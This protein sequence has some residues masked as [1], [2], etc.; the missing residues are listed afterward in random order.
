MNKKTSLGVLLV[1]VFSLLF[2][3]WYQ[4]YFGEKNKSSK[5]SISIPQ[6]AILVDDLDGEWYQNNPRNPYNFGFLK[7][8]NIS[9][10]KRDD[11]LFIRFQLEG[12]LPQSTQ[13][14]PSVDGDKLKGVIF[15]LSI[16]ENYYSADGGRNSGGSDAELK[17]SFY[18]SDQAYNDLKKLTI[19]GELVAGG[20]DHDYF[21][22]RFPYSQ[23][24]FSPHDQIVFSSYGLIVSNNK[25]LIATT[26][27]FKNK[28]R[29]PK[30]DL[31]KIII[32][33]P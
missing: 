3:I 16:D 26:Y 30:D 20:Y 11:N 17:M 8:K 7:I 33:T 9:F 29:A 27:T 12:K 15:Y 14:L 2:G 1:L 28:N 21:V 25:P 6:M 18:G 23:V 10:A 24:L 13:S 32:P 5:S 19:N 4:I 22:V 31:T